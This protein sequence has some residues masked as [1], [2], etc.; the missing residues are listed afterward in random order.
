MTPVQIRLVQ[1]S[2]AKVAP[3]SETAAEIFYNKLFDLDPS[4]K[5]LFK[6]DIKEQGKKLMMMISTAVGGLNH[7]DKI[8]PAVQDLGKR[9]V[10][11]GVTSEHYNTVATALLFTLETGLG[12]DWTP[13]VKDAWVAVYMLLAK[14]MQDAAASSAAA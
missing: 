12:K 3:I 4:L 13:E 7:L 9:H 8:V 10:S 14:T 5:P 6:G 11:Y 1:E 2:F